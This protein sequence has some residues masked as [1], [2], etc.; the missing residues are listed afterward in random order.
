MAPGQ[1]AAFGA[2]PRVSSNN[3]A[4][5][6]SQNQGNVL[7]SVPTTRVLKPPGGASE[8]SLSWEDATQRKAAGAVGRAPAGAPLAAPEQMV[9]GQRPRVTSNSFANGADQNC[10]NFISDTPSTRVIKPP[11]G[12]SSLNLGWS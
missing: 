9:H 11:G 5:G 4:C 8:M 10:G 7:T 3:Y 1:E 12:A 2:R 6:S